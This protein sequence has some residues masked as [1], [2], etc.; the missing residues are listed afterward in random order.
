MTPRL[1]P[2]PR[3]RIR[4]A[5]RGAAALEAALVLPVLLL[6]FAGILDLSNYIS[7]YHRV[8][9]VARDAARVG[10]VTI[11]GDEPTGELIKSE[12]EAH[13]NLALDAAGLPCDGGCNIETE[14]EVDANSQYA[15]VTVA[16]EYPYP[17]LT[18]LIPLLTDIGIATH[19]AM[20]TQQQPAA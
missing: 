16:I 2:R 9:R 4:H 3:P 10:S 8:N 17:G 20:V 7:T 18:G 11:E 6:L 12:A 19:F 14:W 15:F 1:R 5:E 13:A